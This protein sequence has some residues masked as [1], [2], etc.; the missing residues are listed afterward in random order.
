M[1]DVRN[2]NRGRTDREQPQRAE[3]E[4]GQQQQQVTRSQP[5]RISTWRDPFSMVDDL[6]R[7][8]ELMST[9]LR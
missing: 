5:S 4:S 1:A 2:E 9:E 7:I 3:R 6:Q 8:V